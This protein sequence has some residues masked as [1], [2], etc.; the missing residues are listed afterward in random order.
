[1]KV[2]NHYVSGKSFFG[3]LNSNSILFLK[4]RS[5]AGRF[6]FEFGISLFSASFDRV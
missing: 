6:F 4:K 2:Q 1:M 3:R 5:S